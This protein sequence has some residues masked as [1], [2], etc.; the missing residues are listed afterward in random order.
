MRVSTGGLRVGAGRPATHVKSEHCRRIDVR[1][2]RREGILVK[3]VQGTWQWTDPDIGRRTAAISYWTESGSVTIGYSID[4]K[5]STQVIRLTK[6]ACHY[7]GTREWFT[8]PIRGERVAIL[9]L[10][11]GRFACR[12]CQALSYASQSDDRCG[13]AWRKQAKVE[14]KLGPNWSRPKGMHTDTHD[15]LMSLIYDCEEQRDLA[16]ANLLEALMS[17]HP[18]LRVDP[19]FL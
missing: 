17:R 1:R 10:R 13:R 2:W 16:L 5:A 3:G 14:A 8:C 4:G 15:H 11:A 6:T 18:R 9:Y 12:R 19:L 7:G